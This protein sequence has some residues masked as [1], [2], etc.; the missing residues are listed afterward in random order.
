M[1]AIHSNNRSK[2]RKREVA[3]V[4]MEI[5]KRH[6][7]MVVSTPGGKESVCSHTVGL[8]L[9]D[10]IIATRQSR[11]LSAVKRN[12]GKRA[13]GKDKVKIQQTKPDVSSE[14]DDAHTALVN[15]DSPIPV[16]S[17]NSIHLLP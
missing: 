11:S 9:D 14:H 2:Q 7:T 13:I 10:G 15:K 1:L 16:L 8:A 5:R 17:F 12:A 4:K 3:E 6:C